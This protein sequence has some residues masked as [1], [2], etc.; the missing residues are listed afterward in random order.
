MPASQEIRS[1]PKGR[2]QVKMKY[3]VKRN[4]WDNIRGYINGKLS[5]EFGLDTGA[6]REWLAKQ[7]E[8]ER[9]EMRQRHHAE[10]AAAEKL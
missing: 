6:A 4:A 8:R 1:T 9:E 3:S 7:Q 5:V 10:N 2:K